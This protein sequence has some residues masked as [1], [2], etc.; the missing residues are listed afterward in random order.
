MR[1]G[2][3]CWTTHGQ[4]PNVESG[5]ITVKKGLKGSYFPGLTNLTRHCN[6][7]RRSQSKPWLAGCQLPDLAVISS[8]S[9]CRDVAT[10][11]DWCILGRH[12][13]SSCRV[14]RA[15]LSLCVQQRDECTCPERA[16]KE[17]GQI[18]YIMVWLELQHARLCECL[19]RLPEWSMF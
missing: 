8:L 9:S 12:R 7:S 16:L 17:S 10:S 3:M 19:R 5:V 6:A 13:C 18:E 4:E 1:A 11:G 15:C 2:T 14:R